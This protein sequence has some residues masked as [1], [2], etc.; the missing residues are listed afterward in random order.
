MRTCSRCNQ[1]MGKTRVASVDIDECPKCKGLWFE[2]GEFRLAKDQTD[3]DLGWMDFEIWKHPERFRVGERSINCPGCGTGMVGIRYGETAVT[4]DCCTTCHGLWLEKG[5]FQKIVRALTN[6]LTSK[7]AGQYVEVSLHE[8]AELFT[9][10][11][12]LLSEWRDLKAVLRLLQL[13]FFVE[14]PGLSTILGS[15]PK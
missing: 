6:E 7:S 3:R 8:A 13:R 5:E 15:S 11:E 2:D 9:G 12:S 1:Q 10:S 4:V 14:H